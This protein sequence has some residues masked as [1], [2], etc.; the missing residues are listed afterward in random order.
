LS[1]LLLIIFRLAAAPL[2]IAAY[3]L[4]SLLFPILGRAGT[5][6]GAS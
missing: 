1:L 2:I 6:S 3:I 5:S 4:I